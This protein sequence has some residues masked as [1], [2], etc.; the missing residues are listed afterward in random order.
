MKELAMRGTRIGAL[1]FEDDRHVEPAERLVARYRCPEGHEVVIP[2]S[3]EAEEIPMTWSCRCGLEAESVVRLPAM[4]EPA[5]K[6][7]RPV[8]TH[9]DMLLERRTIADLEVLLAER[10]ALL[11]DVSLKKSA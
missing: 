9:W 4:V 1:S 6:I 2:F 5:E 10:L 3:V 8:R 11:H 7:E